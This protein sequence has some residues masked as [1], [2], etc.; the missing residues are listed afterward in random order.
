[1]PYVESDAIGWVDYDPSSKSL[2]FRFRAA[3]VLYTHLDV[4][5]SV[6]QACIAV[7][8]KNSFSQH[9]ITPVFRLDTPPLNQAGDGTMS[10]S[11]T[12]PAEQ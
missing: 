4:P 3:P 9:K 12:R 5:E 8:S 7:D 10:V 2:A 11:E 1:M 6:Y